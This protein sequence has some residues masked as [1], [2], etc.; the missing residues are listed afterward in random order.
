MCHFVYMAWEVMRNMQFVGGIILSE[1]SRA[2]TLEL[3]NTVLDEKC[4]EWGPRRNRDIVPVDF[5]F[6]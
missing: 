1:E 3:F 2:S 6:L 5:N 4:P